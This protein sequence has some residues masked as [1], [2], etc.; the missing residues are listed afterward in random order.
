MVHGFVTWHG[1]VI[2]S[3][4]FFDGE[5]ITMGPKHDGLYLPFFDEQKLVGLLDK[6]LA[7]I[8]VPLG[9]GGGLENR[10]EDVKEDM[11]RLYQRGAI[12]RKGQRQMIKIRPNEV[13]EIDFN[14]DV[15]VFFFIDSPPK[16]IYEKVLKSPEM[17][18][19]Q[20]I[21]SS[22]VLHGLFLLLA[23]VISFRTPAPKIKNIPPRI[24]KLL[25]EKP[26]PPEPKKPEKKP[27][28]PKEVVKKKPE[29]KPKPK[30]KP[31]KKVV[32]KKVIQRKPK[33]IVVQKRI[34]LLITKAIGFLR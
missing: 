20:A 6:G 11:D 28:P 32:K 5:P 18:M 24:A 23:I 30:K 26:K 34:Q 25:V 27:E 31:E 33:K 8:E 1:E 2:D 19:K 13:L 17:L 4:L 7:K 3:R 22:G 9:T 12:K 29:P 15:S 14:N 10:S 21:K 16:V